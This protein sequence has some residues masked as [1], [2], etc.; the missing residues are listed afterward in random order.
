MK[1]KNKYLRV[2]YSFWNNFFKKVFSLQKKIEFLFWS[3]LSRIKYDKAIFLDTNMITLRKSEVDKRIEKLNN[4]SG[5]YFIT[6]IVAK[7]V[8]DL[9]NNGVNRLFPYKYRV[10]GFSKLRE[11][12]PSL[13]PVYYNLISYMYNPANITSQEFLLHFL[14][15]LKLRGRKLTKLQEK[16]YMRFMN[17]LKRAAEDK[18]D[19]FGNPKSL[20]AE[21]ID[22]GAF[23]YFQKK[24]KNRN[25]ENLLNDYKNVSTILLF[26]LLNKI[27]TVFITADRD[28]LAVVLTLAESLTQGMT[29]L[30]FLLPTLSNQDTRDLFSGKHITRF[31][32]F[33]KFKKYNE[34]LLNDILNPYWQKDH[35]SFRVR[36]WDD[37]K[38][39]FVE[40]MV[41][42]FNNVFRE[43]V[44]NMNGPLSCPFAKN[45]TH[46]NW[47]HYIYWPP[48]LKSPNVV[49]VLLSAQKIKNRR[50]IYVP[51]F[52]HQQSCK[53]AI[54]DRAGRL[55][56][57]Y[58]FR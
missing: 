55:K 11:A 27:N 3:V 29:F 36:F 10:V 41:I 37:K 44:L 43:M 58:Y 30:R 12:L 7:E 46:G 1:R 4:C 50:N 39:C 8:N 19:D 42:N 16:L 9:E 33:D 15:Y 20:L 38:Q 32:D 47:L 2:A 17:R 56:E 5:H 26:A 23:Q 54:D 24:I 51:D 18:L 21:H 14:Q 6:D 25:S 35:I 45:N 13:C 22:I 40:D 28:I 57:Y 48:P 49:R 34:G 52:I 53:Y 31:I